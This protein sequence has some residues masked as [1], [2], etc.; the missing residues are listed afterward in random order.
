MLTYQGK[1]AK[2]RGWGQCQAL[3]LQSP[4]MR[5]HPWVYMPGH[6][7]MAH[8]WESLLQPDLETSH[9]CLA[10]PQVCIPPISLPG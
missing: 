8:T 2:L 6:T 1:Q 3:Y 4:G 9:P 10:H 7:C 5:A